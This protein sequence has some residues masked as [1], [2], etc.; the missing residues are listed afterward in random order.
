MTRNRKHRHPQA[1]P[2]AAG[3]GTTMAQPTRVTELLGLIGTPPELPFAPDPFQL[4]AAELVASHD[5]I[6]SAPT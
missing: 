3:P 4:L 6:V 1:P 2:T 5:T